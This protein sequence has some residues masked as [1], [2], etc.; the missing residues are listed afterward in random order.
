MMECPSHMEIYIRILQYINIYIPAISGS[1]S[2][3]ISS[4]HSLC[5][6]LSFV[7]QDFTACRINM[8]FIA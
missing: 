5:V 8:V 2:V 4:G 6:N 7:C 3:V 1:L